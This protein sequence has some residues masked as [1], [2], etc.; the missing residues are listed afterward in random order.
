MKDLIELHEFDFF[1]GIDVDS[2]FV[3][4]FTET[5]VS[6]IVKNRDEYLKK[7]LIDY[8]KQYAQEKQENV[9][10]LLLDEDTIKLIIDLGINEYIRRYCN[11]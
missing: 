3:F 4:N 9:K 1:K 8:A 5:I 2:D 10:V 11:G 6:Q 7:Q